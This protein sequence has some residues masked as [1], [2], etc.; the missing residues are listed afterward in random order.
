MVNE[1]DW[2]LIN[3]MTF[4]LFELNNL[5]EILN[6]S[7]R[8]IDMLIASDAKTFFVHDGEKF[9]PGFYSEGWPRCH[10][11]TYIG[12]TETFD[13]KRW[14]FKTAQHKAFRMTDLIPETER[15]ETKYYKTMYVPYGL[16]FEVVLSLSYNNTFVGVISLY[17]KKESG[18][19]SS[20][21]LQVL[22]EIKNHMALRL[23]KLLY[24]DNSQNSPS[25]T[26]TKRSTLI[27]KYLFT[28]KEYE[29]LELIQQS[30]DD[31]EICDSLSISKNT[32]KKHLTNIY[33]KSNTG[34][35]TQLMRFITNN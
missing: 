34:N 11:A 24:Q 1:N 23:Y 5:K 19:F 33:R 28:P 15:V 14:I 22:E 21:D 26:R 8:S 25:V 27:A 9:L 12:D 29:I 13:Y 17:R 3:Y 10:V 7:M 4:H 31:E 30:L 32:F 35:R 20:R 16:H 18:D 2:S 6:Y